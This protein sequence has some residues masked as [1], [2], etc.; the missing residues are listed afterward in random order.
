MLGI[1]HLAFCR[2]SSSGSEPGFPWCFRRRRPVI[3]M[4]IAI[5]AILVF[6]RRIVVGEVFGQHTRHD[7]QTGRLKDGVHA[8]CI[9]LID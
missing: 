4:R 7:Q 9:V 6:I 3:R 1:L 5:A 8:I 2:S